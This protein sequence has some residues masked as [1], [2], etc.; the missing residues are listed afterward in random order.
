MKWNVRS[1]AFRAA[2][3]LVSFSSTST[4]N[5]RPVT[6]KHKGGGDRVLTMLFQENAKSNVQFSFSNR[7]VLFNGDSA[8]A[9]GLFWPRGSGDSYIYGEGLWFAAKKKLPDSVLLE[10]WNLAGS[11]SSPVV[12]SLLAN[13]STRRLFLANGTGALYERQDTDI[14]FRKITLFTNSVSDTE[15]TALA[16]VRGILLIGTTAGLF[17]GT[18][19]GPWLPTSVNS[20]VSAISSN[21]AVSAGG[22][23]Y[24]RNQN[25]DW[26]IH[27][28]PGYFSYL[29][30]ST[31]GA[32]LLGGSES[33]MLL[34]SQDSGNRWDTIFQVDIASAVLASDG[35]IVIG[36]AAGIAQSRDGS[37]WVSKNGGLPT[38]DVT[39]LRSDDGTHFILV[40]SSGL[41]IDTFV[42]GNLGI[43]RQIAAGVPWQDSI[44]AVA[45]DSE[46]SVHVADSSGEIYT[47]WKSKTLAPE[48]M[49]V[50]CDAGYNTNGSAG[51]YSEGEANQFGLET[52]TD[53][54][55]PDSKYISYLSPRYD[56]VTGS[57]VPGSTMVVP[58]PYYSW[59]I[60]DTSAAKTLDRNYY[61]GN[62]ISDVNMR[63]SAALA[64]AGGKSVPKPAM[65]SDEDIVNLYT[66]VD[67]ATHPELQSGSGGALG[68]DVQEVTSGW[69]FGRYRD[70]IFVRYK[71]RNASS[72]TLYNCWMAPAFDPDLD[73][74]VNGS[75]NDANSYVNNNLVNELAD[76]TM[77]SQLREPYRSDPTK[78]QMAV[79][80]RNYDDPPNGQQYGWFGV[81]F[82]ETPVVDSLGFL[83]PN[84]DSAALRGYG[85]NSLFQ[86]NQEGLVTCMGWVVQND[87]T[88]SNLRYDYASSGE[89]NTFDGTYGD[90]RLLIATG[91]FTLAPDSS[92]EATIVLTFAHV[93]DTSY[94]QNFGALLLLTDFAHQVFGEVDS[95]TIGGTT[96]Y[97]VNNFQVTPPSAVKNV[98]APS[99]LAI[100]P[101]YPDPFSTDCTVAYRT[102]V[103]GTVSVFVTDELGRKVRS[104]S[105]G[106][107]SAGEHPLTIAGEGLAAG[108]YRVTILEG[109][110]SQSTPIVYRP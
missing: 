92:A 15:I 65:F 63:D 28:A 30:S 75:D 34:L 66:D 41:F 43:W 73:A 20:Y 29:S 62:Y 81:A 76:P 2:V 18:E 89:K 64:N 71:V 7:G 99:N 67:S 94:A 13:S 107:V 27:S 108:T 35:T 103:S 56:P 104:F 79:Q 53:G 60:W 1:S 97:F 25:G 77:V 96:N 16:E 6:P 83:I 24:S 49:T 45:I 58:A 91:P 19:S 47:Q 22:E 70:M 110:E 100:Q 46:G 3:A 38:S 11:I 82:V 59:P 105:L 50:Y 95:S 61:F 44:V 33:G 106:E 26:I 51:I 98:P 4:L 88:S 109:E 80:W 55:I 5:A 74:A 40:N 102:S 23:I 36:T 101:A 78:L 9:E 17:R 84:D 69:G 14:G 31:D 39:F 37:N 72:D 54:A 12:T 48:L 93:S 86:K 87:P 10:G 52:G 85:P 68:I 8:S 57:Y 90:Q 21:G 32:V 42:N